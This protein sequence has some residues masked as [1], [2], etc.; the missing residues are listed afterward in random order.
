MLILSH[1]PGP[2]IRLAPPEMNWLIGKEKEEKE[3]SREY[4]PALWILG[5]WRDRGF[6]LVLDNHGKERSG[7]HVS[8]QREVCHFSNGSSFS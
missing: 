3:K 4:F 5:E 6:T 8:E 1:W 7:R 2:R